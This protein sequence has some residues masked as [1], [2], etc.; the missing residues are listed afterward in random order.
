MEQFRLAEIF[1]SINGEGR[2]AGELLYE[3]G[4]V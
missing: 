2:C 3:K 4:R 1:L